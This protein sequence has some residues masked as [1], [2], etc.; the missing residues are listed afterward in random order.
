MAL[1]I[2]DTVTIVIGQPLPADQPIDELILTNM[3]YMPMS[4]LDL[5]HEVQDSTT[6]SAK[7]V[8][9]NPQT[10]QV[11]V[12]K[13]G[14]LAHVTEHRF[15]GDVEAMKQGVLD[16]LDDGTCTEDE[17][18]QAVTTAMKEVLPIKRSAHVHTYD[19]LD[20]FPEQGKVN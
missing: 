18:N 15:L 8:Q 10:L 1:K 3:G 9:P 17:V 5:R 16:K 11:T 2:G 13:I 19:K 7:A 4:L 20:L 14:S 6:F 12:E